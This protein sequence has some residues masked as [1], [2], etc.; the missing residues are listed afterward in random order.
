MNCG[1]L[2]FITINNDPA[3]S[4]GAPAFSVDQRCK[5]LKISVLPTKSSH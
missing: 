4:L 3:A 1:Y 5:I 2:V